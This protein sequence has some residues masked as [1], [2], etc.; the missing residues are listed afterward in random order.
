MGVIRAMSSISSS[1]LAMAKTSARQYRSNRL[2]VKKIHL[3]ARG[4]LYRMK[5]AIRRKKAAKQVP[6][7]VSP[8]TAKA[9]GR[10]SNLSYAKAVKEIYLITQACLGHSSLEGV[11]F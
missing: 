4:N 6:V 3:V 8:K 11:D 5:L 10:Y 9:Y 2:D 7:R 1:A